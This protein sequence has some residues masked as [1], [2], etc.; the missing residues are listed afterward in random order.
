MTCTISEKK[1]FLT[2]LLINDSMSISFGS[3]T[4]GSS[5][6]GSSTFGSNIARKIQQI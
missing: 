4:F 3:T 6:F 5:T 2:T 1:N